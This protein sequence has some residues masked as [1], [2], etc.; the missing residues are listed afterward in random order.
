MRA[1]ASRSSAPP[2]A[3]RTPWPRSRGTTTASGVDLGGRA[4]EHTAGEGGFTPPSPF[5]YGFT[6]VLLRTLGTL[7]TSTNQGG[8]S[9]Y[10]ERIARCHCL[11]LRAHDVGAAGRSAAVGDDCGHGDR[12]EAV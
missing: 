2:R 1:T 12:R 11:V 8:I 3:A 9:T 10:A 6:R 4:L 5:L 7:N